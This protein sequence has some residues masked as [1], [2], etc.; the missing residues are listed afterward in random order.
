MPAVPSCILD[1]LREQFLALLP[2]HIDD[3]PLG[4]H[5]PRIDDVV[6]LDKLMEALVF[7]AGYERIADASCSA[8]TMRRRRDEWIALGVFDRLRLACLDAYEQMIGL[9]LA[10]VAVDGCTTKAPC[11]GECA[12]RS[13]VDRGKGGMKRSQLADGAGVPMATVSAPANTR[14]DALLG[15]TLDALKDFAPLPAEVTVH[16]DAG[17]DYRPCREALEDRGLAGEIARR[18]IPAPIQVGKRWPVERTNSWLNDFGRLRR[19][20]ERRRVC[21]DAYLALAA[22]IVT[23]RALC[24]AAWLLYRWDSRP[25]SRRIR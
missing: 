2:P 14:D 4:C 1:P 7:G 6:V 8:T 3:H 9:D 20:T 12:G 17:Y 22:A 21:V 23:V 11:G 15:P 13:P 18:G 16:L 5:R 24:R 19:C 25:R 10:D